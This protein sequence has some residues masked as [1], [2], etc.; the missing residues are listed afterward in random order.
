M[1]TLPLTV[2]LEQYQLSSGFG[3]RTDPLNGPKATHRGLDFRAAL[4]AKVYPT[5]H[6]RHTH[7]CWPGLIDRMVQINNALDQHYLVQGKRESRRL[8]RCTSRFI[9]INTKYSK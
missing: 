7:T 1:R 6:D 3:S 4:K 8:D 5:P 9:Q 2:P